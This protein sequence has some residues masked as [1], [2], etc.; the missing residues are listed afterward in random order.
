MHSKAAVLCKK[1]NG[2][3]GPLSVNVNNLDSVQQF[4]EQ[5]L[6]DCKLPDK[7][8]MVR[9]RNWKLML[10]GAASIIAI[11]FGSYFLLNY[12]SSNKSKQRKKTKN[13]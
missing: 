11:G 1:L 12:F 9:K 2:T 5:L 13:L 8:L 3:V 6:R 7:F 4:K 10:L